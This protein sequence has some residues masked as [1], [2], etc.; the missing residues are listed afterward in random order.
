MLK[1]SIDAYAA[2][3]KFVKICKMPDCDYLGEVN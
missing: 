1:N 2:N 3:N